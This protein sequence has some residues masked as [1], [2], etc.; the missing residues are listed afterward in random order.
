MHLRCYMTCD[1]LVYYK[2]KQNKWV[3]HFRWHLC[4]DLDPVTPNDASCSMVFHGLLVK[5]TIADNLC[6]VKFVSLP[7]CCGLIGRK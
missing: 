6:K 7:I 5:P 2:T 4:C 1:V 3:K